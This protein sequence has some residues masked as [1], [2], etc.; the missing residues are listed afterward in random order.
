M[1][2]REDGRRF[3]PFRGNE[4]T[5]TIITLN[6]AYT[7]DSGNSKLGFVTNFVY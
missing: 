4:E 3:G 1:D 6:L 5:L 2:Q 7:G